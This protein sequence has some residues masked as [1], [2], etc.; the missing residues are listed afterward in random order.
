MER[1]RRGWGGSAGLAPWILGAMAALG[2]CGSGPRLRSDLSPARPA[3]SVVKSV[4]LASPVVDAGPKGPD[5]PRS[6]SLDGFAEGDRI[7]D[8]AGLASGDRI[9]LAWVTYFDRGPGAPGA[10]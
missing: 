10:K 8:L 4:P 2:G 6:V 1:D 5:L 3:P 7:A 9:V